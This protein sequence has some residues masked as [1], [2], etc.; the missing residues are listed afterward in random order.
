MRSKRST[1]FSTQFLHVPAFHLLPQC[2]RNFACLFAHFLERFLTRNLQ[3][4]IFPIEL[5]Q[6]SSFLLKFQNPPFSTTGTRNAQI[7]EKLWG[8]GTL[9]TSHQISGWSKIWPTRSR[10]FLLYSVEI[11]AWRHIKILLFL[12]THSL[13]YDTAHQYSNPA[14][15]IAV[16]M[17]SLIAFAVVYLSA[18]SIL[19]I[20]WRAN[21]IVPPAVQCA[22]LHLPLSALLQSHPSIPAYRPPEWAYWNVFN[23]MPALCQRSSVSTS[24]I[25]ISFISKPRP[26][27]AHDYDNKKDG[28]QTVHHIVKICVVHV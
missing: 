12:L 3:T 22:G 7:R 1:Q 21:L 4:P 23:S 9:G 27:T 6:R 28:I 11:W 10:I 18:T 26:C 13:N 25:L 14:S 19:C 17:A 5:V 8:T 16:L 15:S 24:F 2:T 20:N